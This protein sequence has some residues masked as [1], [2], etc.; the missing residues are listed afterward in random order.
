MSQIWPW[1]LAGLALW[2]VC[3]G[4]R[5][6]RRSFKEIVVLIVGLDLQALSL[7]RRL[8]P[9]RYALA[10]SCQRRGACCTQIIADPPRT[11]LNA[12]KLLRLFV[13][14]HRLLH[15]FRLVGRGPQ[16]Q[17]VFSCGYVGTDGRCGI[18][19]LRPRL[20]RTYPLLP[21]FEA[22]KLLPGCG[23]RVVLRGLGQSPRLPIV[24]PHVATHHPTPI[25]RPNDGAL[26]HAEDFELVALEAEQEAALAGRETTLR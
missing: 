14:F 2:E 6:C 17:L 25:R 23:Y 18:Y 22:P 4:L 15:N 9:P 13:A 8:R 24:Q 12:P 7:W 26:E 5:L 21:Y 3:S 19:R 20:C 11:L 1:A 10:G 16:G